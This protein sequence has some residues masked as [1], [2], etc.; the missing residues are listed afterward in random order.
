MQRDA[1]RSVLG[2]EDEVRLADG[3]L[4]PED[5]AAMTEVGEGGIGETVRAAVTELSE[6]LERMRGT[7]GP[8]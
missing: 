3:V 7:I 4:A 6:G 5:E 2:P 1:A 8:F